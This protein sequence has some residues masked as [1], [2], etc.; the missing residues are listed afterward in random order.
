MALRMAPMM[1]PMMAA[2]AEASP[3]KPQLMSPLSFEGRLTVSSS[4][5][6]G[7]FQDALEGWRASGGVVNLDG[8]ELAA[9]GLKAEA[10]GTVT[11][12]PQFR[13]LGTLVIRLPPLEPAL[14]Q[15]VTTK[16]LTAAEARHW[17]GLLQPLVQGDRDHP[18]ISV[19]SQN[20]LIST[21]TGRV[22]PLP[23]YLTIDSLSADQE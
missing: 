3:L 20:G 9:A 17:R 12:D 6:S 22:M 8:L 18:M 10:A 5:P 15:L 23:D 19:N 16:D 11:I 4:L 7:R 21:A 1:A 2:G 13:L 14:A